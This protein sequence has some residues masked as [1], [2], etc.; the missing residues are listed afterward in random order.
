MHIYT[1]SYFYDIAL[2]AGLLIDNDDPSKIT[3]LQIQ[4]LRYAAKNICQRTYTTM[5]NPFL[6][7][8]LTYI[9]SLLTTG[10]GFQEEQYIHICKKIQQYEVAWSLGLALKLLSAMEQEQTGD[11]L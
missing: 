7:F 8:D 6:C 3:T 10:Y 9:Y 4:T 5:K 2:D 11:I 1:F